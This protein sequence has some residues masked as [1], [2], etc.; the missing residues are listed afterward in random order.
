MN[1]SLQNAK[2][3]HRGNFDENMSPKENNKKCN[4]FNF[5][6]YFT[7]IEAAQ[8]YFTFIKATLNIYFILKSIYKDKV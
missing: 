2:A 7:F 8:G 3:D 4:V 6:Y 1:Y 5:L